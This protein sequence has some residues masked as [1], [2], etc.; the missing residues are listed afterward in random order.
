MSSHQDGMAGMKG[1]HGTNDMKGTMGG[2][3]HALAMAYRENLVTFTKALRGSVTQTKTVNLELARPAVAE[4]RRSLE[5]MTQHH[6]AQLSM[7][8]ESSKASMA[9]A[10]QHTQSHLTSLGTHL[11]AL[12]AE[13]SVAAPSQKNVSEHATEILK[14]CAGM[15]PMQG[16]AKMMK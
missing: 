1:M 16:K 12:D 3:H 13:L 9:D 2:P 11:S 14:V 6:Q 10:M 5:Q 15:M 8:S 7:M 4:M